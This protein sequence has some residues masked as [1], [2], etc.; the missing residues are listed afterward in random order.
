[1]KQHNNAKK[2]YK[3]NQR[4]KE[5]HQLDIKGKRG[6]NRSGKAQMPSAM[7]KKVLENLTS[8]RVAPPTI[9]MKI[10][11]PIFLKSI[12]AFLKADSL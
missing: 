7:V 12:D 11:C 10:R 6:E 8:D 4:K 9:K 3:K 2:K 1:M 5:N